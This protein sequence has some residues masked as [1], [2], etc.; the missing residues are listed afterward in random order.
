MRLLLFLL[1]STSCLAAERKEIWPDYSLKKS[2]KDESINLNES[3][4]KFT[5]DGIE[6]N[7]TKRMIEYSIDGKEHKIY[8]T[9]DKELEIRTTPGIHIF[10]FFYS[11]DYEE[12]FTDSI[13]IKP[14]YIDEYTVYLRR[15]DILYEVEKPVIYLYPELKMDVSV[16][17]NPVGSSLFTYPPM[18]SGWEITAS[19]NGEIVWQNK[20]YNYLFWEAE[21]PSIGKIWAEGYGVRADE[22]IKFLED[23]LTRFGLNSK[24][25]AD[26]ITYWGPQILKHENVVIKF[27]INDACNDF[28]DLQI[29]PTPDNVY[30]IYMLWSPVENLDEFNYLREQNVPTINRLGF[31]VLEWGGVKLM[32]VQPKQPAL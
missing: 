22:A 24:E 8:L 7:S 6:D 3:V 11:K 9:G 18:N 17:V 16:K 21:Q 29:S 2:T 13:S 10:V 26:F 27:V 4:F 28:A 19:P 14:Q 30:R 31:T 12:I 15:T 32:N 1:M 25:Q 23:K 5:F 20:T